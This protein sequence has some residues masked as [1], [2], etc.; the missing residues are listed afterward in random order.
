MIGL[1]TGATAGTAIVVNKVSV[2]MQSDGTA[3]A[4]IELVLARSSVITGGT[5]ITK[6]NIPKLKSTMSNSVADIRYGA[7]STLGQILRVWQHKATTGMQFA[8]SRYPVLEYDRTEWMD[9]PVLAPGE[10]L[11][12]A[13]RLSPNIGVSP[14]GHE[15]LVFELAWDEVVL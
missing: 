8:P 15:R 10:Y 4:D 14:N 2:G 13:T 12:L 1:A 9:M 5:S 7:E 3:G 11:A 6:S